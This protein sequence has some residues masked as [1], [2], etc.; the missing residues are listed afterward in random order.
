MKNRDR[1]LLKAASEKQFT[2]FYT[3]TQYVTQQFEGNGRFLFQ[4]K[5]NPTKLLF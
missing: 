4:R 3:R 1:Q 5:I 2:A